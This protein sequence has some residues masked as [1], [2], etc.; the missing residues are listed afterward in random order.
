MA[1]FRMVDTEFWNDP[2]VQEQFTPEDKLFYLY[3]MTNPA[4][5]QIGIYIITKKKMAFELGYSIETINA[6]MNR[7]QSHHQLIDY[8]EE[9]REILLLRWSETAYRKGG[10]PVNDLV[11]SE[12]AHVK[13]TDWIARIAP[14]IPIDSVRAVVL[15]YMKQKNISL[16]NE[17]YDESCHESYD[18]TPTRTKKEEL[19]TKKEELEQQQEQQEQEPKE[20]T[21]VAADAPGKA[22]RFY[23]QNISHLV[24][25]IAERISIMIDESSEELVHEA[26]KRSVEG[27]ARNK[28]NFADSILKSW[29]DQRITTLAGVEAA[30]KE[31]ERR[32]RGNSNGTTSKHHAGSTDEDWDGLSL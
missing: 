8:D 28:M 31:F 18:D 17:S 9:T 16:S 29:S 25:H 23:E 5:K 19:R 7:F 27:N 13:R 26:L 15:N 32:K 21:V 30:D 22:F 11:L 10:K 6:L 4:T 3:L 24:P 1:K 12:L 2:Q 20:K 14:L